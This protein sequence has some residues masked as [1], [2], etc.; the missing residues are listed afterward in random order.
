MA[1][2]KMQ[3]EANFQLVSALAHQIIKVDFDEMLVWV[4]KIVGPDS[5]KSEQRRQDLA[6]LH[7]VLGGF[8]AMANVIREHGIPVRDPRNVQTAA[9]ELIKNPDQ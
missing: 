6:N 2:T 9:D 7:G 8:Q 1:Y 4:D 5:V 3:F